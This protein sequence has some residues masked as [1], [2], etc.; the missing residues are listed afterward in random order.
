MP[1]NKQLAFSISIDFPGTLTRALRSVILIFSLFSRFGSIGKKIFVSL[2]ST[3]L[4]NCFFLSNF[5]KSISRVI[6][7]IDATKLVLVLSEYT[8]T[9]LATRPSN[10]SIVN[11]PISASIPRRSN[12]CM[13]SLRH[14]FVNPSL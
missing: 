11:F 4:R 3:E 1:F 2:N 9:F 5:T 12:S 13:I 8:L 14:F 7:F 10:G 6:L